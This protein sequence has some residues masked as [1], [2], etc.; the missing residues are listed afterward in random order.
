MTLTSEIPYYQIIQQAQLTPDAIAVLDETNPLTYQQLDRLSNQ[1]A[2]YLRTQGV[3]P[4][5]R[6]GIMAERGARMMIGILGILKAGG[7]YIPLDP[8]YPT[9]RLR[10]ILE[11]ATIQTL[12]TEH[13]VSQQ[14]VACVQEALPLQT[15]MFLDEGEPL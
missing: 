10:Y 1:V 12:L 3:A 7:S 11:H 5:T 6:V 9:D 14:L 13:Q 4:N 2:T 15:V 8:G